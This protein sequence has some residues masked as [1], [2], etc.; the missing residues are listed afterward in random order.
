MK[1]KKLLATVALS[2][3]L[4]TGCGIKSAQ[5]IIKVNGQNITQGQFD[6]S[7]NKSTQGGMMAQLGINVK[8]GKN[9]FL[10]Y[11]IKDKV[12]NDLIV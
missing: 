5:T 9:G 10:Y 12:V 11:L 1:G 2:A 4:F 8:D 3:L 6:E 7:F